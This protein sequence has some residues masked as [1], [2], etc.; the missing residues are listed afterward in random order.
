[1]K[2]MNKVIALLMALC[3]MLGMVP[4]VAEE[5]A[6]GPEAHIMFANTDW[7][8]Q[9][10]YDGNDYAGVT[11]KNVVVTGEGDYTVGLEF[12]NESAGV[13]FM[14]LGLADG[15]K[16]FPNYKFRINEIRVNGAAIEAKKGYTSSDDGVVTRMNIYNEW[17]SELPA[18]ARSWDGNVDDASWIIVD[19]EEFAAVKSIEVD[20]SFIKNGVDTAYIMFADSAWAQ[21]YW[22]DGN[23]YGGVTAT[24][25]TVTGAGDY[26]V[27]LDFTTTEAGVASGV[28]FSALGIKKGEKLFP[29]MMIKINDVKI[30][31]ASVE[32]AKGYTSS[33]D[34]VETRMNIYNEWVDAAAL[35]ADARSFDGS[36]EGA[37]PII[38]AKEAFAEVKTIEIDF[39]LVPVTDTAYIMFADDAWTV[40]YWMDGNEYAGVTATNATIEGPGTYTVGLKFDAATTG[41]AFAALGIK[42]GEKTFG[43]HFIDI[44]EV[45]I[46]GN[47]VEFG[48]G[49]TSS[50][51]KVET[52]T[53]LMNEWVSELPADARRADADL[54]GA[55]WMVLSKEA[56]TGITS[57]EITFEYIYGKPAVATGPAPL[58][59][60]Q[61]AEMIAADYNAYIA[62]QTAPNY[63]FRNDWNDKDYGR[64]TN[65]E[66]YA[67]LAKTNTDGG[68]DSQGGT[69]EDAAITGNGTYTCKMTTGEM[70]LD[71]ET[72]VHFFRVTTDIPSQLVKE[73]YVTISDVSLKIGEGKTNTG[74]IV[75][76]EGDYVQFVVEDNY[77]NIKS[78]F[79]WTMPGAN[80]TAVISFT[81]AGLAD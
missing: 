36:V 37:S 63:I 34:Q 6:A 10:W 56:L 2:T 67:Q 25:A 9:Y 23:A 58:T 7:S 24:N 21:Q 61:V 18:D 59:E 35:P 20:F 70:G 81:V 76:T 47:A 12:E 3:M 78:D 16:L 52:R 30:N 62:I 29:G 19:K 39:T 80:T 60:D 75:H 22:L 17:V 53:N 26:K 5:A 71:T 28:A 27:G 8:A 54:E 50:D 57:L 46:D 48:K 69:F 45:K 68:V 15:E 14:A 31:G 55:T 4:A 1:M 64:D 38:I 74:V 40:Q 42:T 44:K 41:V 33:D 72:G 77:N 32:V 79:G 43:G 65:P 66:V 73:G 51:D 49:Y 11:A 13:A